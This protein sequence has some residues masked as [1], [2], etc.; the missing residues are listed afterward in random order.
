MLTLEAKKRDTSKKPDSFRRTGVL[1]AVFYGRKEKSTPISLAEKD[2]QKIWKEAGETSVISLKG[3]WGALE[4][5]I[6][7][8]D[9]HPLTGTPRHVDF[10]VIE[11]GQKVK[12]KVPLE[13]TGVSPAVKELGAILIKVLHQL[14][15]EA[16]P[17]NL[18]RSIDVD[19]SK[20]VDLTSQILAKDIVLP[21]GVILTVSPEEVVASVAE[22]KEEEVVVAEPVDLSA[23]ELSEK[24]GKEEKEGEEGVTP[25]RSSDGGGEVPSKPKAPEKK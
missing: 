18:P 20:L 15:I 25:A 8:V 5:L 22:A 1:P 24:K 19:I 4:T 13:F 21:T 9:L 16:E 2:F 10:Y 12:V 14:E 3:E 17:K 7:D 11:K 6:N 23:I